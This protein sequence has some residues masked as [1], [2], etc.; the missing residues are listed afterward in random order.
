MAG[1]RNGE[2]V[3]KAAEKGLCFGAAVVHENA[4]KFAVETVFLDTV[5]VVKAGKASPA[6]VKC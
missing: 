2:G 5:K 6:D 1:L 3:V 4:G